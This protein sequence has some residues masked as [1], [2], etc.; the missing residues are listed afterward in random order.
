L[1]ITLQPQIPIPVNTM[2]TT[3]GG[4]QGRDNITLPDVIVDSA[5]FYIRQKITIQGRD[6][7]A[8]PPSTHEF[9]EKKLGITW[10]GTL[11]LTN[12]KFVGLQTIQRV[13]DTTLK[14]LD[15]S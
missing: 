11:I 7:I 2:S 4:S 13:G 5:L 8:L 15:V 14:S 10:T 6:E 1:F 9:S 3:A 12:G